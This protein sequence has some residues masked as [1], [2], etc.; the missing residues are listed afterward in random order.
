[1]TSAT[2]IEKDKEERLIYIGGKDRCIYVF[3]VQTHELIDIWR[4]NDPI[5]SM[6]TLNYEDG[7]NCF[8]IGCEGGKILVR[9]DWEEEPR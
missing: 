5:S 3:E 7:G 4:V 1:M 6:H 9:I 2:I 8:A